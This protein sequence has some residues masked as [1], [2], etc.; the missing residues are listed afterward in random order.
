MVAAEVGVFVGIVVG[1]ADG[2]VGS[3]GIVGDDGAVD[4]YLYFAVGRQCVDTFRTV[5]G[6]RASAGDI[7]LAF[8]LFQADVVFEERCGLVGIET[9]FCREATRSVIAQGVYRILAYDVEAAG[10]PAVVPVAAVSSKPILFILLRSKILGEI[11]G[12][13][14]KC[15][16]GVVGQAGFEFVRGAAFNIIQVTYVPVFAGCAWHIYCFQRSTSGK[17]ISLDTRHIFAGGFVIAW[18]YVFIFA[19]YMEAFGQSDFLD[20]AAAV[21]CV[22]VDNLYGI[23]KNDFLDIASA[24]R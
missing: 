4:I 16:L 15:Y 6:N 23:G 11:F 9:C 13:Y 1:E 17:S 18:F 24:E 20:A 10:S 3:N 8:D 21:E 7:K 19:P 2:A 5:F 12:R 22:G 14:N